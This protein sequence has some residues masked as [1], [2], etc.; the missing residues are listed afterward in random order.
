[1]DGTTAIQGEVYEV[2]EPTM[3]RLDMLEG[4]PSFYNR[5]EIPTDYGLA[6]MYYLDR[7]YATEQRINSGVW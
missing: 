5:V 3:D 2:D 6:W 1:M 7:S 4:Y